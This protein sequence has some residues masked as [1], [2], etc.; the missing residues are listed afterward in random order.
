MK[1]AQP[2][3]TQAPAKAATKTP[4]KPSLKAKIKAPTNK[5]E[6][7][8]AGSR[9]PKPPKP[10]KELKQ[11][12]ELRVKLV[13][14]KQAQEM[15]LA[16]CK[17]YPDAD[18]ELDFD[19]TF[20]L[21]TAVILS[22]QTTDTQVNKVTPALFKRFP[23]AKALAEASPE[24]VRQIIRP[25]GYF[26]AKAANIQACAQ[27]LV[28]RHNGEVPS[29]LETLT[30]L[31]GV[32]RKTANVVLGV[33]FD[34]PSWTVDTHVNRLSQRLGFSDNTDPYKIEMDLQKLFPKEDWSKL[35][36]TLIW[37]GRR[38]CYARKPDCQKCPINQL[39][40]SAFSV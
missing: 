6:K 21:L 23:T 39:C 35:S 34:V 19:S 10:S 5:T 11:P 9:P 4:T 24:E 13:G 12:K 27:A 38:M 31:P 20:Q 26:N 7:A 1:K 2:A 28:E 14:Q 22:A 16:L 30:K 18:C 33:V 3:K 29:D 40:P 37:H 15:M 36:I 8:A 17:L 25:T 32:G